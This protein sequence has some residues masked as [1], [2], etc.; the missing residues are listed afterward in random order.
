[1]TIEKCEMISARNTETT[2][3]CSSTYVCTYKKDILIITQ[4]PYAQLFTLEIFLEIA[5]VFRLSL[6][7]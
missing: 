2:V 7:L 5:K 1:M 3:L 4:C 6:N